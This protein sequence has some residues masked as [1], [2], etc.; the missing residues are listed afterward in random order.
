M[1]DDRFSY[2]LK[3]VNRKSLQAIYGNIK[4]ITKAIAE[5]RHIFIA[6]G[7]KDID[8]LVKQGYTAFTYGSSADWQ[9][10]FAQLVKGA[11]VVILADND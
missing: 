9:A 1:K 4:D 5:E 11:N 2:G 10:S 8:S 6:E 3:G 7:E